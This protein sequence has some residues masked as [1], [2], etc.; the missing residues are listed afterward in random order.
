MLILAPCQAMALY[1]MPMSAVLATMQLHHEA[2]PAPDMASSTCLFPFVASCP[3]CSLVLV[4]SLVA[5][6]ARCAGGCPCVEKRRTGDLLQ[7]QPQVRD[8]ATSEG[9]NSIMSWEG[10]PGL[11]QDAHTPIQAHAHNLYM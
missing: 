11:Q 6:I 4:V 5:L 10:L 9:H 2:L 3:L 7:V 8:V 1:D